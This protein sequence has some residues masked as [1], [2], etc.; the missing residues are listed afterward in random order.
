MFM[1]LVLPVHRT[2]A[3]IHCVRAR[4]IG[5]TFA[6]AYARGW[7]PPLVIAATMAAVTVVA[8]L[9]YWLVD[10]TGKPAGTPVHEPMRFAEVRQLGTAY[11]MLL[12]LCVLWYAAIIAFRSTFA[13][14]YFQHA[15]GLALDRAGALNGHV[16]L[17]SI[18]ATP[19]F[20]WLCS[21]SG[22]YSPFLV[23]AA[24]LFPVS[25][26]VM[27]RTEYIGFATVLIGISYCMLPAVIWPLLS[28]LVPKRIFGTALGLIWI[29]QNAGIG[30][31]NVMA[32][33]LN[34]RAGASAANPAGYLPMMELFIGMGLGGL[35]AAVLLWRLAGRR[36]HEVL[37]VAPSAA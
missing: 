14:K 34:D 24:V 32:G 13:V 21:R 1:I 19:V 2:E 15:H 25:L 26:F 9:T 8:A 33:W 31:A 5:R 27:V 20:G 12:V 30:G 11:W 7:Q 16:F 28:R 23:F 18:F 10:R 6:E 36:Q 29:A 3:T 4:G 35:L 37:V 17:A 22:R